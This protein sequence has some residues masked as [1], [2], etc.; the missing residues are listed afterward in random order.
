MQVN[1]F[2]KYAPIRIKNFLFRVNYEKHALP[3]FIHYR[4]ATYRT[5][6]WQFPSDAGHQI[7]LQAYL[8]GSLFA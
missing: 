3:S 8:P 6:H 1:F 2:A 7:L 5:C 4:S